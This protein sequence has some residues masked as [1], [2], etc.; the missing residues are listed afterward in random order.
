MKQL[1]QNK[2]DLITD[3]VTLRKIEECC[4]IV[5]TYQVIGGLMQKPEYIK[6]YNIVPNDFAQQFYKT[7]F[8]AIAQLYYQ[9]VN[10]IDSAIIV[11]YLKPHELQ[12]AAFMHHEGPTILMGIEEVTQVENFEYNIALL[13]KY[14]LLRDYMRMGINVS[15]FYDYEETQLTIKEKK[16]TL[17]ETTPIQNI[18][19]YYKVQQAR[20]NARYEDRDDIEQKKAGVGGLEQIEKWKQST[21]WGLGYASAY[22]NSVTYGIRQRR[23]TV[24]SSGSGV[25]KT[26]TTIGDIAHAFAPYYYDKKSGQWCEN[27]N[28]TTNKCLYIGTEMELQEEIDPIL[29]AYI[30]DVPQQHIEF[31]MYEE[32][33]EERVRTAINILENNSFI[34]LVNAPNYDIETLTNLIEQYK[35][36]HN[37]T[38]VFFDYIMPT[39]ALMAEYVSKVGNHTSVRED[40]VLLELS[41]A[42]KNICR[43]YN[44]SFDT[45]TQI[46]ENSGGK[47]SKPRYDVSLVRGAKAIVD[48]CDIAMIALPPT[49]LE[50]SYAEEIIRA[51][52]IN[53]AERIAYPRP[54]LVY[55]IYKNRGGR[56]NKIKIWL[57]VDY[58]TMRVHD[59]FVTDYNYQKL[60]DF[61]RTYINRNN[62]NGVTLEEGETLYLED[63]QD[64][65]KRLSAIKKQEIVPYE[66]GYIESGGD[67]VSTMSEI[68]RE[69]IEQAGQQSLPNNRPLA[70]PLFPIE[71]EETI[72]DVILSP[73]T[74]TLPF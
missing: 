29:Y 14:A 26:R 32:G 63:T 59:L 68:N 74:D 15:Y 31:N 38:S 64:F 58:S 57:Y 37:I 13:K 70:E 34:Y 45:C 27:P 28:G 73:N 3:P 61:P 23:Y 53:E 48:K 7:I 43:K 8:L 51:S 25:G 69:H 22:L 65:N 50:M 55:S 54:N 62:E 24:K 17:I 72:E 35:I 56:Y 11:D 67:I 46:T 42:L 66:D 52:V 20:I 9:G 39:E 44:V 21:A 41:S 10:F 60:S 2:K 36:E 1:K 4:D 12:Y 40:Q 16:R 19:A 49:T 6:K 18:I 30:A 33:E 47:D 5:A 71:Q